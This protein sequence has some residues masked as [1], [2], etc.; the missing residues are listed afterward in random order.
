MKP[1]DTSL[2]LQPHLT[3][4]S[5]PCLHV[6]LPVRSPPGRNELAKF[7]VWGLGSGCYVCQQPF[8]RGMELLHGG[9]DCQP[10]L[11]VK[12]LRGARL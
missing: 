2:A 7:P 3:A 12:D 6:S 9:N 10:D 4:Y 8:C 1:L 5:F 11:C